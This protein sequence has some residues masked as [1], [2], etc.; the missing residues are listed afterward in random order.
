ML[1]PQPNPKSMGESY[2]GKIPK[3]NN[4]SPQEALMPL[5]GLCFGPRKSQTLR[6]KGAESGGSH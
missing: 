5:W 3:S 4:L 1:T 2:E 6:E